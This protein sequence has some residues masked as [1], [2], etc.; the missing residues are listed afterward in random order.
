MRKRERRE[1][2]LDDTAD[3]RVLSL[4]LVF[5]VIQDAHLLFREAVERRR[6]VFLVLAHLGESSAGV[7]AGEHAVGT[8]GTVEGLAGGDIE[9]ATLDRHVY[10][11][12][13]I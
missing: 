9:D 1:M 5:P 6:D 2:R 12:G 3:N 4:E 13:W 7:F 11:L 10:G 8:A